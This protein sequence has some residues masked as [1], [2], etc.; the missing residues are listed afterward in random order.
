[1]LGMMLICVVMRAPG[2]FVGEKKN[3]NRRWK[4]NIWNGV[5][6]RARNSFFFLD[7]ER[8]ECFLKTLNPLID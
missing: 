1:M 4:V 3:W 2:D 8:V 7:N 6:L 5:N